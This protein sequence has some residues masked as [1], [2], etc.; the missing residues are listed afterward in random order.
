MDPPIDEAIITTFQPTEGQW[1]L[2]DDNIKRI[3]PHN[4]RSILHNYCKRI[5]TT[6]LEVLR[7]LIETKGCDIN[8]TDVNLYTPIVWALLEF[9]VDEG[10]NEAL[11]Y[12]LS[13]K[14]VNVNLRDRNG[15]DLLHW[16]C[17]NINSLPI[18]TFKYLIESKGLRVDI[19]DESGHTALDFAFFQY[20]TEYGCEK[21][22]IY[23]M[24]KANPKASHLFQHL[25]FNIGTFPL[26]ITRYVVEKMGVDINWRND[27]NQTPLD[28]AI[29]QSLPDF[30]ALKFLFDVSADPPGSTLLH[31]A[32][33]NVNTLPFLVLRHVADIKC[34]DVNVQDSNNDTPLHVAFSS[35]TPS[36]GADP[37]HVTTFIYQ[38]DI[39]VDLQGKNGFNLLHCA[40]SNYGQENVH[41]WHEVIEHFI[42]QFL[43]MSLYLEEHD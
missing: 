28:A 11:T 20:Q 35:F 6:P 32:Y 5:N 39:Q 1:E 18:Q 22:L 30:Q 3:D 2:N 14:N 23:V 31:T 42:D 8:A 41:D 40:C 43:E 10:D 21:N 37:K 26:R 25:L 15:K 33:K 36:L 38:E 12:L 27:A 7:Y 16:A 19:K 9:Q 29:G 13:H 17:Y 34:D 24:S 4:G